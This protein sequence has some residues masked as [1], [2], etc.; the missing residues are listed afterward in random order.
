MTRVLHMLQCGVECAVW[1][2]VLW[3]GAVQCGEVRRGAVRYGVG[4]CGKVV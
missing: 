2:G 3:S 4:W 1:S